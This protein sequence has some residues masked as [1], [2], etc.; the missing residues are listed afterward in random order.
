[1]ITLLLEET[2]LIQEIYIIASKGGSHPLY[3]YTNLTSSNERTAVE[4]DSSEGGGDQGHSSL[5]APGAARAVLCNGGQHYSGAVES[6]SGKITAVNAHFRNV[7][8]RIRSAKSSSSDG[9]GVINAFER[10][11]DSNWLTVA[12]KRSS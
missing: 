2:E 1:M 7:V 5:L 8:D 4:E 3:Y 12:G 10:W 9:G 6:R 11:F